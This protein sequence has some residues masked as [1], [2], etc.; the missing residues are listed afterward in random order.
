[1]N[2]AARSR[3]PCRL[4]QGQAAIRL[5]RVYDRPTRSDGFR[6]PVDRVWPRGVKKDELKVSQWLKSVAPSTKLRL[7]FGHD[8]PKWGEFKKRYF[9]ELDS[10]ADDVQLLRER[11]REGQLTLV[12]AARDQQ[13]N[14]AAARKE[15]LESH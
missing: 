15:Y 11:M 8:P 2:S 14:N 7:W 6:V 5:K 9:R 10:R 1:M 12:F 3:F 4:G 13:F